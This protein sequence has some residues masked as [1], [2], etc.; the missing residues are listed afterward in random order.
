MRWLPPSLTLGAFR[1][2]GSYAARRN[3]RGVR[4]LRANLARVVAG[5]PSLAGTD[6][7]ALTAAAMRSYARYW[8]EVF[9][10]ES[11]SAEQI[12]GGT[13]IEGEDILRAAYAEGNGLI[14]ALP[15]CGNWDH[16]GA[17]LAHVGI[18]FTTVA[19]RLEPASVYD[20][21]VAFRE[22]LGMEVIPLTGG[23]APFEFLAGR[24]HEGRALCLLADR[25]LPGNG[26]EVS[27]F[28]EPAL[29]P[30]GPALLAVRTG[31][32]LL[33]VSLWFDGL[34]PWNVRVHERIADPGE[35]SLAERVS[36]MM[37]AMADQFAAGI[38]EHPADWHML[39][40]LWTADRVAA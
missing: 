36:A 34:K 25:D 22:S 26:R 11:M 33:P 21:F 32:P 31:A 27:F 39:A 29:M 37:Q 20:R 10:L 3:G 12:V 9:R 7:D 19:E 16:A 40:R 8:Q 30:A 18:P 24:L 14:L 23:A 13:N 15:H 6:L 1:A 38:A 2:A 35:G 5:T 4:Q 17:W 28:G